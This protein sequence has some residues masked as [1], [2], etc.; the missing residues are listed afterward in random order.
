MTYLE[1]QYCGSYDRADIGSRAVNPT[2]H[3]PR[4]SISAPRPEDAEA[5]MEQHIKRHHPK[6]WRSQRF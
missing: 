5:M 2:S 6:H 3:V 4:Y 1:C